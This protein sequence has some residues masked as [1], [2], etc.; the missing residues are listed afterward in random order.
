VDFPSNAMASNPQGP[1]KSVV[2]RWTTVAKA[3]A[4]YF[5]NQAEEM[6]NSIP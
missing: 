3:E 1:P 6:K 5:F 2:A 4:S